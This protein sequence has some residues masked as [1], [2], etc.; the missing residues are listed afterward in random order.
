[1]I[2]ELNKEQLL[3][4]IRQAQACCDWF[5]N[6]DEVRVLKDDLHKAERLLLDSMPKKCCCECCC[7]KNRGQSCAHDT[8]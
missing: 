5:Y 3:K 1:M 7:C 2:K 4:H 8:K 6:S